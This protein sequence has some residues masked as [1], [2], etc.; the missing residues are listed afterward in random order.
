METS[1]FLAKLLGLY[2]LIVAG[3]VLLNQ[4]T[5]KRVLDDLLKNS[6]FIYLAGIFALFF[7]LLIVLFHNVWV[8]GWPVIVTVMGWLGLIKGIWIIVFPESLA[9]VIAY[10]IKNPLVLTLRLCVLLFLGATLTVFGF[11]VR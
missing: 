6:A 9:K 11:W 3:G 7:G 4:K 8:L 10:H 2:S 5:Y 1:V